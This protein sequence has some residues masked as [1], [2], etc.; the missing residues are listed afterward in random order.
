MTKL[1]TLSLMSFLLVSSSTIYTSSEINILQNASSDENMTFEIAKKGRLF[2]GMTKTE[3]YEVEG[4][5]Y[6]TKRLADEE[7][8]EMWIYQ[9]NN[10]MK[11]VFICIST[12]MSWTKSR[13][14]S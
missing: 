8:K 10:V 4:L 1:I 13:D 9:C 11:T 5:P 14:L 2:I 12:V 7:G 3:A 6:R